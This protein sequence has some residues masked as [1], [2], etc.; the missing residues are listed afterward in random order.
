MAGLDPPSALIGA[1]A[2]QL[3]VEGNNF[4]RASAVQWQGAQLPT[5]FISN[6]DLLATVPASDLSAA[7]QALVNVYDP[8][9]GD[10]NAVAFGV[11]GT[12]VLPTL[13]SLSPDAAMLGDSTATLM[14]TGTNFTPQSA[15]EW[16][17]MQLPTT[18]LSSTQVQAQVSD[19][20][21]STPE[22]VFIT[23]VNPPPG[24]GST[25]ALFFDV[26]NP[27]PTL[28]SLAPSSVV[29]GT[30]EVDVSL[31][32][33]NFN[34]STTVLWNG[35]TP[36]TASIFS[37]T[38]LSVSLQSYLLGS[39][40]TFSLA[41]VNAAPGGGTA[42]LP[43]TIGPVPSGYPHT[44]I[45]QSSNDLIWNPTAGVIYLSV[46]STA[47]AYGNTVAVLDPDAGTVVTSQ[48]AGSEPSRL[49]LS[50]D[51]QFLY[52]GLNGA[53]GVRR[54]T[55]PSL[56]ASEQF[57]L[58]DSFEGANVAFDIQVAPALPH[59]VAVSLGASSE[60][61]GIVIF[62]DELPRATTASG[63]FAQYGPLA[64]GADATKLY[65]ATNDS[66]GGDFYTLSVDAG[67]VTQTGD[68]RDEIAGYST[69]IH[70]D[71]GTGFVYGDDGAIVDP[72]TGL[73]VGTFAAFTSVNYGLMV[74]DSKNGRAFFL[75]WEFGVQGVTVQVFDLTHFTQITSVSLPN[76]QGNPRRFIRWG[77]RGLAF[78]TD[79][80]F[81][82][83]LSGGLV[84]GSN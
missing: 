27:V 26:D 53:A 81:V 43:F 77:I 8:A 20:Y 6:R 56:G 16:N 36:L 1:S 28:T 75:T 66:G 82:Y 54:F 78:N 44:E 32:G 17:G 69:F 48:F 19:Y 7:V 68:Y 5:T 71:R 64:W 62:D 61:Q 84:D 83:L 52:V 23:V 9:G 14:L 35:V 22:T 10:S 65:A 60:S 57:S 67:G 39:Q 59:T 18:Y 55:L 33:A 50:E 58:G 45:A 15:V 41:V 13:T 30:E 3:H 49:A 63:T 34:T 46:P 51:G 80:G 37:P 79:S 31:T 76:V 38:Q 73:P 24:G 2:L 70:F 11:Q 12:N 40:G 29:I 74:P 42:S 21:L 25:A 4:S 72:S 47:A